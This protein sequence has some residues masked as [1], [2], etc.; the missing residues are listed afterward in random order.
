MEATT[1][2]LGLDS[3]GVP[4]I[5]WW[6]TNAN[7]DT[8]ILQFWK[9][10]SGVP[11]KVM[12]DQGA[13]NDSLAVKLV[14]DKLN[15]RVLAH[16]QRKDAD[17]GIGLHTAKSDTGGATWSTPVVIPPDGNSSTDYPFDLAVDSQGRG[18]A[19]FGQ[20]SGSGDQVCG[21]PKISRTNDFVTFKTCDV[22]NDVNVTG[23]YNV[24]PGAIQARFG[25]NDKVYMLWWDDDGI[26]MYREPPA[27]AVTAPSI[28]TVVNGATFQPGIVAG[29]WTTLTGANLSDVT[30]TWQDSD[31]NGN[32]LPT[33][34]SGVSVKINGLDAPVYFVS[35][36]QINVQAPSG[37]SGNVPVQVTRSGVAGNT[38]SAS[39]VASAP[40]LFTYTLGGKTYPSALY[41][42]T[43]TIVGDPALY[44]S[45]A[46]AKA[47]DI[48]QLYATALGSSPAGNIIQSVI[49]FGS[50]VSVTIGS[51]TV[52]A[53]FAGVV[54]T[55]LFQ[56]NFTVP[57][58]P[59]GDYP[60]TIKVGA[61]ASQSGVILPMTH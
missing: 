26:L 7:Q 19:V 47:G 12:D 6:A 49:P 56:I 4:A 61:S 58:L 8:S 25:E 14:F 42:G 37:I 55:G 22:V 11:I 2:S 23:A 24:Y 53:S 10:D 50:P 41:N 33:N 57:S 18:A 36:T 16:V 60:L 32:I 54:G 3:A 1:L 20:N 45:S 9:P 51:T 29:S 13:G 39:A 34:L 44:A 59:D 27:G 31:F 46:K 17:F 35:P 43:Y 52:T 28:S 30:R 40:G 48:I 5:A 38:L 15:P 21:N